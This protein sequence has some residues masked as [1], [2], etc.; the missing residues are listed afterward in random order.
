MNIRVNSEIDA[1]D[2]DVE[3]PTP[4]DGPAGDVAHADDS[5]PKQGGEKA[6]LYLAMLAAFAVPA[7]IVLALFLPN[8]PVGDAL[9]TSRSETSNTGLDRVEVESVEDVPV[10]VAGAGASQDEVTTEIGSAA[11]LEAD[12]DSA[13]A[14]GTGDDAP[15]VA[16]ETVTDQTDGSTAPLV[17]GPEDPATV[18]ATAPT[19]IAA[20]TTVAPSTS[21]AEPA[22]TSS[23]A[24]TTVVSAPPTTT[25]V[26]PEPVV[27]PAEFAQRIDIGRIGEATVQFRFSSTTTTSYVVTIRSGST[28]VASKSG[29]AQANQLVNETIQNLTPGTDYTVQ[30]T[31]NGPPTATSPRV[32]FRTSG[33]GTLDPSTE[34]VAV[35][36]LRLASTGSTRFEVQYGSNICA[37][38]SFVIREQGGPIV[39]SNAGQAAGCTTRHLAIPGFWT[40]A[41]KPNTTYVITVQVEANGAGQGNGNTASRSLVVTTAA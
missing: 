4:I 12:E 40:P 22:P 23:V 20:S 10:E 36:N 26:E 14:E 13:V 34:S 2:T 8:S 25:S 6:G 9:G 16:V 21:N 17:S 31:L 33:G 32:A 35:E 15:V 37:N 18:E 27:E 29:G 30:V 24:P 28:T 1:S 19:T 7:L 39:G 11:T 5:T 3:G 38:G 41:L